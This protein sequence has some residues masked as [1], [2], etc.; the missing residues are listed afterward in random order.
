MG[1]TDDVRK[2]IRQILTE[3]R[4]WHPAITAGNARAARRCAHPFD[5][6]VRVFTRPEANQIRTIPPPRG[7]LL[8]CPGMISLVLKSR[9]NPIC[10]RAVANLDRHADG[11]RL[12]TNT[13]EKT[14]VMGLN[15]ISL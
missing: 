4:M 11:D 5:V 2:R 13:K 14:M 6:T 12:R 8:D 15:Y 3:A 1:K 10:V 9:E 7:I